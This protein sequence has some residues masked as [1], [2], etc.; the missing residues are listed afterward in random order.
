MNISAT[1]IERPIA[2]SLLMA[3]IA[4]F[5]TIAYRSLPISDLPTVANATVAQVAKGPNWQDGPGIYLVHNPIGETHF[6]IDVF[7]WFTSP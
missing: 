5:G 6:V 4:L 3:A 7:G 2:T 1:F